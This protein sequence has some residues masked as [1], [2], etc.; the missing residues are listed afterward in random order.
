MDLFPIRGLREVRV[1]RIDMEP[2]GVYTSGGHGER[3]PRE[4][5]TVTDGA[6]RSMCDHDVTEGR[7]TIDGNDA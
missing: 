5:L 6:D 7:V 3:K 2:G 1:Y 4:Y